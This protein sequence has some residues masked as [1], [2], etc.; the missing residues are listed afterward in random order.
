LIFNIPKD[1]TTP[2]PKVFFL[3]PIALI[4][5]PQLIAI[6]EPT[7]NINLIIKGGKSFKSPVLFL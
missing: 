7:R 2:P 5:N 6:H 4:S 3:T 1:V